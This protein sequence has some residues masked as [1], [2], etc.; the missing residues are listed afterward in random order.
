MSQVDKRLAEMRAGFASGHLA[1]GDTGDSARDL[2]HIYG[3]PSSQNLTL[4]SSSAASP[5]K[6]PSSMSWYAIKELRFMILMYGYFVAFV[7]GDFLLIK[8]QPLLLSQS[9]HCYW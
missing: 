4:D 2:Q 3:V 9:H 7:A 8:D 6:I 1:V 5:D